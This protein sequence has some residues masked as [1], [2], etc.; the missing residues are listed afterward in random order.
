M[1]ETVRELLFNVMNGCSNHNYII[2][3]LIT[4]AVVVWMTSV[5]DGCQ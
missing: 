5:T 4:V 3:K 1:S 2:K